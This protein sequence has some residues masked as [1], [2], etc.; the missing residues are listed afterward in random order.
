MLASSAEI[1][2][3]LVRIAVLLKS[4]PTYF[5]NR[6][7]K[8]LTR[9]WSNFCPKI[10]QILIT[11]MFFFGENITYS[12]S[13]WFFEQMSFL[14]IKYILHL[15]IFSVNKNPWFY[16]SKFELSPHL[17]MGLV[18]VPMGSNPAFM[19]VSLLLPP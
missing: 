13:F 9:I 18:S 1:Q 7:T 4:I 12:K 14:T 17:S 11:Y 19:V 5:T 16:E 15:N 10:Q 2:G 3:N 8:L 6:H